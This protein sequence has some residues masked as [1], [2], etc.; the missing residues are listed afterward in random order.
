MEEQMDH[1]DIITKQLKLMNKEIKSLKKENDKLNEIIK[2][3]NTD[4]LLI[5]GQHKI[6]MDSKKTTI[7]CQNKKL[8]VQQ[9]QIEHLENELNKLLN[10]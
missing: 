1:F 9:K 6:E 4:I 2:G 7:K 10:T 3:H 8:D 5:K